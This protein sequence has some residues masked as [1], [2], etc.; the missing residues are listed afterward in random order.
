LHL[1]LALALHSRN[2]FIVNLLPLVQRASSL[3]RVVTVAAAGKEGRVDETDFECWNISMFSARG[4]LAS[5]IT[6]SLE[7]IAKKAPEVSFIHDFPGPVRG[8]L[9]KDTTGLFWFLVKALFKIIGPFIYIPTVE[10]GERHVF[11]STSARYPAG[12][13]YAP[14]ERSGSGVSLDH[15][16][17]VVRGVDGVQGGG[18]YVIDWDGESASAK[19]Q[20]LLEGYRKDGME[21]KV[22]KYIEDD[23]L[24][25]TGVRSI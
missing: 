2:R 22:W 5:L 1:A 11:V 17:D 10:S 14:G 6:L 13:K 7:A 18:V 25:I 16:V 9:A 4:H 12:E 23:Y 8:G 24:R 20:S 21:D 15:C 19:V 3:R